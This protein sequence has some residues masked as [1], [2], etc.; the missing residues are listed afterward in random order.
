MAKG[1]KGFVQ[2]TLNLGLDLQRLSM[3][4][5]MAV[6]E[7]G[8][9]LPSIRLMQENARLVMLTKEVAPICENGKIWK[10]I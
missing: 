1:M 7:K 2:Q 4:Q 3:Q 10:L 5:Q 9:L 6:G 8:E